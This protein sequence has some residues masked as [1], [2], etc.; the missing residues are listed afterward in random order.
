MDQ[1]CFVK[2]AETGQELLS[3]HSNKRGAQASKLVLFDEFVQIYTEKLKYETEVLPMY[4]C[5]L[6]P[7][8]MMVI[9]L[10]KLAVE[11]R[12]TISQKLESYAP[13]LILQDLTLK[14]P[15]YFD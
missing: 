2:Q 11:L 6:K 14:L 8:K 7:Q 13:G 1:P 4:E 10:I 15:S 12:Q 5:I 9:I 3:E